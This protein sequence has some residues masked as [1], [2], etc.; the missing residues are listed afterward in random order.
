MNGAFR[1]S[2]PERTTTRFSCKASTRRATVCGKS[3]RGDVGASGGSPKFSA[4]PISIK[5]AP[6]DCFFTVA[7]CIGSGSPTARTQ[8]ASLRRSRR[9]STPTSTLP[10]SSRRCCRPSLRCSTTRRPAGRPLTWRASA[11]T[12]SCA[13]S[14]TKCVARKLRASRVWTLRAIGALWS[15]STQPPFLLGSTFATSRRTCWKSQAWPAHR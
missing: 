6:I 15:P 11:R 12:A 3:I 2:T 8:S 10:S 9:A 1:T 13:T 5:T 4:P 14:P 7:I